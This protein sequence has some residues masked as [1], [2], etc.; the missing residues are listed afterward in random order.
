MVEGH[1]TFR[2]KEL[3]KLGRVTHHYNASIQEVKS[4]G[5]GFSVILDY[6]ESQKPAWAT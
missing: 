3:L 4:G 2:K 5:T 1:S 6:I